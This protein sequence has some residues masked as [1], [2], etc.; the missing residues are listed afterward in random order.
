MPGSGALRAELEGRGYHVSGATRLLRYSR[1]SLRTPPG[2]AARLASVPRYLRA[3]RAWL[4]ACEPAL[5]HANTLLTI[6]EAAAGRG[7]APTVLYSHETVPSGVKGAATVGLARCSADLV[8]AISDASAEGLRRGGLRPLV[9]P[10]GVPL[11][12]ERHEPRDRDALVVGMLGTV[13]QRKGSDVFV[14]AIRRLRTRLPAARYRMI[15]ACVEGPERRWAE[16][17]VRAARAAGVHYVVRREG[18]AELREWDIAVVAS[19]DEPFGLVAAE[20]MALGLPVVAT[21]T[22]GL[23]EVIGP[24]AGLLVEPGDPGALASAIV[25]LARDPQLRARCGRAGR[26]RVEQRFTLERQANAVE[27]AY[28]TALRR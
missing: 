2:A 3:F 19:R 22:G 10:N 7:V 16:Q 14:E 27:A 26:A 28:L 21:R 12:D 13:S 17:V 5:L 8:V 4:R 25:R 24:E 23:P 1:D 9:V 6:P 15:G 18:Y 11:P 20:A